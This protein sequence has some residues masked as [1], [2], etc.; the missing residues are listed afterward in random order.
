MDTPTPATKLD[1]AAEAAAERRERDAHLE[2]AKTALVA[3]LANLGIVRIEA[4]ITNTQ[5]KPRIGDIT[6]FT[7][8]TTSAT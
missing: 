8:V 5:D 6:A 1:A 2:E 3:A 4:E 7:E